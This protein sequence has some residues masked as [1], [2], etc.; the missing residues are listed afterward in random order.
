VFERHPLLAE[1]QIEP[2]S[3]E[4]PVNKR[5]NNHRWVV[6]SHHGILLVAATYNGSFDGVSLNICLTYFSGSSKAKIARWLFL[7]PSD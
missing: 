2:E 3:S 1:Q 4:Q 7:I 5:A 6:G